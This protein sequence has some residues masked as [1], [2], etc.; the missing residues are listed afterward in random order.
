MGRMLCAET[1]MEDG[2][3]L[4]T[5]VDRQPQ[6]QDVCVAAEPGAQFVQLE[7]RKLEVAEKVL[8]EAL[9]VLPSAGRPGG[10]GGLTVSEDP[11]SGGWVQPFGACCQHDCDL[12]RGGFQTIEG[13]VTPG[14]ER[15]VASLTAKGLDAFGLAMLTVS[16]QSMN[17]SVCDSKVGTLSIRTGEAL[18]VHPLRG[19][20]TAF[21]L[22]P[23]AHCRRCWH[24][25]RRESGGE[26]TSW[27]IGWGARLE[28]AVERGA[29]GCCQLGRAM[30]RPAKETQPCEREHEDTQE[31]MKD[32]VMR[33]KDP[34][35]G[36]FEGW[37]V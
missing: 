3:Y 21:D 29:L 6:P 24:H 4:R 36:K 10:D 14:S 22:A 8:V 35:Y 5:W 34:H 31:Q 13:S 19:S 26:S 25:H 9:S 12:V 18:C 33:H 16:N 15:G 7:I 17:V 27:A 30:M 20:P 28:E 23:G 1:Q 37:E 2:K 11:F 32:H